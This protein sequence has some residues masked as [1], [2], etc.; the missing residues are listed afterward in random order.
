MQSACSSSSDACTAGSGEL[1]PSQPTAADDAGAGTDPAGAARAAGE[2][3]EG[4]GPA[5]GDAGRAVE[6]G[7][8]AP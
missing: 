8:A 6:E 5:A 2:W 1:F 7:V 3:E 4:L